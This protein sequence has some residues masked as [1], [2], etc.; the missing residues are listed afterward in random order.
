MLLLKKKQCIPGRRDVL[1][2]RSDV[3]T[4]GVECQVVLQPALALH[5]ESTSTDQLKGCFTS[6]SMPV[7]SQHALMCNWKRVNKG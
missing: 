2:F 6:W 7:T 3:T 5:A 4:L 1:V